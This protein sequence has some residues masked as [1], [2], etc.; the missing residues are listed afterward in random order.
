MNQCDDEMHGT[1]SYIQMGRHS[2]MN[3][4]ISFKTPHQMCMN[5]AK[6]MDRASMLECINIFHR[7]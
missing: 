2:D 1:I 4:M 6:E 3:K 7:R 5:N